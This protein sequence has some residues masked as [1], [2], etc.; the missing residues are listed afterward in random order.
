MTRILNGMFYFLKFLLMLLAFGTSLY[1]LIAMY[2][3]LD[4]DM[5]GLINI[6][7]PYIILFGLF[8]VNIFFRQ[9][10]VTKN[11]FFNLTCCLVFFT[12]SFLALRS[13]FD[14]MMIY[15]MKNSYHINFNFF[16]DSITFINVMLYGL[17]IADFFLMFSDMNVKRK[18]K[19]KV[20][21]QNIK[22]KNHEKPIAVQ[23]EDDE[24]TL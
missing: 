24:E 15:S 3:R 23:I 7:M 1:V 21:N 2:Q 18:S 6:F 10:G 12:I 9:H 17:C 8:V 13:K 22:T 11:V 14:A 4:K 16:S 5:F 19:A 20:V